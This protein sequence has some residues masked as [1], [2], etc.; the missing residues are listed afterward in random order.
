MLRNML[1]DGHEITVWNRTKKPAEALADNGAIVVDQAIQTASPGGIVVS[2][3]ADDAAL[4]AVF[5]D[6][7]IF[8]KLG[9]D[10]VHVSMSTCSPEITIQLAKSIVQSG[11]H[12]LT[13]PVLGRPDFVAR[14]GHRHCVSGDQQ[15]LDRL[16]PVLE[17]ISEK[18]F[19][20]GQEIAAASVAKLCTNFMIASAVESMAESLALAIGSGVDAGAIRTMWNQTYFAGLVHELYSKQILDRSFDPL[21]AMNL[22]LKDVGLFTEA[23]DKVGIDVPLADQLKSRFRSGLHEGFGELDFTAIAKLALRQAQS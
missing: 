7:K 6:G 12:P 10:G 11:G 13:C 14:R 9:T 19:Y 2:C 4:S 20:L 3:L 1:E 17:P 22:M 21:F 23:A 8:R 16:K 18:I 15:I 5:G